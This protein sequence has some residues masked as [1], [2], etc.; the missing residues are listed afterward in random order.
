[1]SWPIHDY[2]PRPEYRKLRRS[3]LI[4]GEHVRREMQPPIERVLQWIVDRMP[5][6]ST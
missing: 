2:D 3:L 4:A 5:K 6:A 1:M